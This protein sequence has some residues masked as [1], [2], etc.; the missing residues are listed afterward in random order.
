M[1]R[2]L[3]PAK[4]LRKLEELVEGYLQDDVRPE[5]MVILGPRSRRNSSLQGVER[6]AGLEVADVLEAQ[7]GRL[8]Y[9]TVPAFKGLDAPVVFFIDVDS[10]SER[11]DAGVRYVGASRATH[12]LHVFTKG[13][14]WSL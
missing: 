5:E 1:Y 7:E 8:L 3:G 12:A 6:I 10:E 13:A 11:C 4:L 9:A 14:G 2:S